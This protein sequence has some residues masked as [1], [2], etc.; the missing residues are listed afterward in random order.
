MERLVKKLNPFG[1]QA[2]T[3]SIVCFQERYEIL[4]DVG[5]GRYGK[6][7]RARLRKGPDETEFAVKIMP[8]DNIE[9]FEEMRN[10]LNVL[11][12][13]GGHPHL[14]EFVEAL[15]DEK[16][17]Y[18]VT[19]LCTGGELFDRIL[20]KGHFSEEYAATVMRQVFLALEY[21][22][23]SL[24]IMH[25][26]LKPENLIFHNKA[27]SSS[28]CLCDF[29]MARFFET[30]KHL[31][32]SCGSPSYVAP[33]VLFKDYDEKCDIWSAGVIL[34]IILCGKVP[35]PGE[36][37]DEIMRNVSK[38]VFSFQDKAWEE[39][40]ASAKS[41]V[42]NCLEVKPSKRLSASEALNHPW[43]R[44]LGE[45]R[46]KPLFAAYQN[47]RKFTK[48]ARIKKISL[49]LI[50]AHLSET[51]LEEQDEMMINWRELFHS[52]DKDEK[53]LIDADVLASAILEGS[54]KANSFNVLSS[55]EELAALLR[56]TDFD[57]NGRIDLNEFYAASLS[58]YLLSKEAN[59]RV[60][61][62]K[63]DRDQ[64]GRI[65][66]DELRDAYGGESLATLEEDFVRL[67]RNKD[68][69]ISYDEFLHEM[70]RR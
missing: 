25:R 63:I 55:A 9:E 37:D 17:L 6:V 10:E 19:N 39:I 54:K 29:G 20:E 44:S 4:S 69:A 1:V 49:Q 67:D 8:K 23:E 48:Q 21:C 5:A 46:E 65:S 16:N 22:H 51:S 50:A 41:L 7:S 27:E 60:A 38:G 13:M 45:G 28:L 24:H 14:M 35:F 64:D 11:S 32:S 47:M 2:V 42:L 36:T 58:S 53:G 33:E 15:E 31:H 43:I 59:L 62:D 66:I 3:G 34:Y 70:R 40:S 26:D 56:E 30:N 68:G 18:I 12:K 57:H 61:F 52:L